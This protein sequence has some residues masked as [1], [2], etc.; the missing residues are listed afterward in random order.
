MYVTSSS[1]QILTM[2]FTVSLCPTGL[3]LRRCGLCFLLS[4]VASYHSFYHLLILTFIHTIQS[5]I[6]SSFIICLGLSSCIF[7]ASP[8]RSLL[9]VASRE[10]NSGQPY[11]KPTHYELSY[12]TPLWCGGLCL[13]SQRRVED[14]R[15]DGTGYLRVRA[16]RQIVVACALFSSTCPE[17]NWRLDDRPWSSS[18]P[19]LPEER[20]RVSVPWWKL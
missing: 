8:L 15:P 20:E 16:D 4:L 12:A 1:I 13:H 6:L 11:S 19:A 2:E 9:G 10:S 18:C 7:I 3:G 5:Y 14:Q 17:R